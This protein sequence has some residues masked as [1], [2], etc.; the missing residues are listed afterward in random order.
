MVPHYTSRVDMSTL[1]LHVVFYHTVLLT[2]DGMRWNLMPHW[3]SKHGGRTLHRGVATM[4]ITQGY[5]E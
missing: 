4:D 1:R 5:L 3:V 2:H